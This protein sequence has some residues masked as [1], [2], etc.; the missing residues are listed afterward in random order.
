MKKLVFKNFYCILTTALLAMP[1]AVLA[2]DNIEFIEGRITNVQNPINEQDLTTKKYVDDAI[3]MI[4]ELPAVLQNLGQS[5][6]AVL[7]Q[8]AVTDALGETI[9][10]I[11]EVIEILNQK[12]KDL[13]GKQVVI[14]SGVWT[15]T[16]ISTGT[17]PQHSIEYR[18]GKFYRI[19]NLVYITFH[20]KIHITNVGSG[21]AE[22][23]GLPFVASTGMNDQ[24]LALHELSINTNGV[25]NAC[26]Y[27]LDG[28]N[29]IKLGHSS[30]LI[31]Q[32]WANGT[33]WIGF[34]GCYLT[35]DVPNDL[36]NISANQNIFNAIYPVGS[37]YMSINNVNPSALFGGMWERWG[38]G[39]TI[40]GVDE[41]DPNGYFPTSNWIGGSR[42]HN[43]NYAIK[44][45]GW[46]G[47]DITEGKSGTG[48]YNY[49]TGQYSGWTVQGSTNGAK[50]NGLV[51]ASTTVN[52][53]TSY[54]EGVTPNANN[55]PPC[56]TCYLWIRTA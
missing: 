53:Q 50:N 6:I 2:N 7:S 33:S 13:D 30:G 31:S 9:D 49:Q 35:D 37:I 40:V 38:N 36:S 42:T 39:K 46:Y 51:N 28:T 22:I 29:R 12:I 16:A 27:V 55:W 5:E 1:C 43:H 23:G 15:P 54:S 14:S 17:Y 47:A 18:Y 32:T 11:D 4:P 34:S 20:M 52:P 44:V 3:D 45:A 41:N 19:N 48:A 26:C 24:G 10:N 21:Y 8:K 56:I 25:N